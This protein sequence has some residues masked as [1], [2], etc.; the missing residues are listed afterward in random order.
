MS[1]PEI[2][3][4]GER[5]RAPYAFPLPFDFVDEGFQR[6]MTYR[7]WVS[8]LCVGLITTSGVHG[9]EDASILAVK[10]ADALIAELSK[11]GA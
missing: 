1:K 6:G 11:E 8:G 10:T 9:P 2:P 5:W 7:E 4:Q 3:P